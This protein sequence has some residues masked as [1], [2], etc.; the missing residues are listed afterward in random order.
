M[1]ALLHRNPLNLRPDKL[2]KYTHN[3]VN[4]PDPQQWRLF[5]AKKA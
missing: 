4:Q 3:K 5:C 1:Q 2:E